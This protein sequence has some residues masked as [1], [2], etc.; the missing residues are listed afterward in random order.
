MGR[1]GA[2]PVQRKDAG[3]MPFEAQGKAGA[4]GYAAVFQAKLN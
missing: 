2:A 3:R 4:T 1:S